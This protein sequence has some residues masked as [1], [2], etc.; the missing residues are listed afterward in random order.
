MTYKI[1]GTPLT[2]PPT[3]GQWKTREVLG[4]DGNGHPIYP[5]KY[6]FELIW[7][8][9][10]MA[11]FNQLITFFD[12]LAITG[13]ASADLPELRG[14]TYAFRTYSGCVVY[15]PTLEGYFAQFPS[16][17]KLLLTNISR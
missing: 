6:Q 1:N 8:L 17:V 7:D 9:V 12:A 15:E 16:R 5:A 3:Q 2:L 14:V 11:D 13:T 10:A 4:V